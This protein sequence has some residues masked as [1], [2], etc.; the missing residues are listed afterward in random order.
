[1]KKENLGTIKGMQ[2]LCK[3]WPLNG[4]KVTQVKQELHKKQREI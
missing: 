4:L 3:I 2:L 1:M